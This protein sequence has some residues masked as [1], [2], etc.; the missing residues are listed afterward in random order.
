M[1]KLIHFSLLNLIPK[2]CSFN[3]SKHKQKYT[4][5]ELI[6]AA[7]EKH[8]NKLSDSG[9]TT[10]QWKTPSS[11]TRSDHFQGM[12]MFC[13]QNCHQVIQDSD[14]IQLPFGN[15]NRC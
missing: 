6:Q 4:N 15:E 2:F 1:F 8:F 14:W 3:K 11:R 7:D 13:Q 5:P 10:K 12:R 9:R